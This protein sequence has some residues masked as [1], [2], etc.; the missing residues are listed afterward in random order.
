MAHEFIQGRK[1]LHPKRGVTV[2]GI[3]R[4]VTMPTFPKPKMIG[5]DESLSDH[6]RHMAS[7]EV[8]REGHNTIRRRGRK[9]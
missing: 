7:E 1:V 4:P 3:E 5:P 8:L 9:P 2:G 6:L